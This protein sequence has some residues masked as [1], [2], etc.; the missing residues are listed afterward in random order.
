MVEHN[1]HNIAAIGSIPILSYKK[2][3]DDRVAHGA[4]L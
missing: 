2:E 3:G 1:A 4:R